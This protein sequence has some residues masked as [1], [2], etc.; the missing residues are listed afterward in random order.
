MNKNKK[1]RNEGILVG[2]IVALMGL[3]TVSAGAFMYGDDGLGFSGRG[4]G[5]GGGGG[6]V[7]GSAAYIESS[8]ETEPEEDVIAKAEEEEKK[9][10]EKQPEEKTGE[11]E[12][13]VQVSAPTYKVSSQVGSHG[14]ASSWPTE[15]KKGETIYVLALPDEDY[16]TD[17]MTVKEKDGT[18]VSVTQTYEGY[19]FVM[20]A[21]DVVVSVSF[22]YEPPMTHE[23]YKEDV[24]WATAKQRAESKGGKLACI[25]SEAEFK[26]VCQLADQQG[27][28]YFW[29]GMKRSS[30]SYW[31]ESKWLDG[32]SLGYT[33]WYPGE[34]SYYDE[35]YEELYLLIWKINDQ[36]YF[37]DA[38]D[39]VLSISSY[40]GK[41]GYAVEY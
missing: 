2:L 10:A 16:I 9:E 1:R 5:F 29:V 34:P 31:E 39:R 28:K 40:Q 24:S 22:K 25:N 35:S 19:H 37:N 13:P 12:N 14:T 30:G 27:V 20:P 33:K 23:V 8:E 15:A 32:S 41:I 21:A 3:M 6:G 36:W 4:S 11:E 26:S 17:S 18:S 7:G 38:S